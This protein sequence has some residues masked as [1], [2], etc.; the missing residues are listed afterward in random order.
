MDKYMWAKQ[1]RHIGDSFNMSILQPS[2]WGVMLA[3]TFHLENIS[4]WV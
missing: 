1:Y 2:R 3:Y 4:K